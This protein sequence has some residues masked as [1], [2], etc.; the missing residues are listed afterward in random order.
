MD[1]IITTDTDMSICNDQSVIFQSVMLFIHIIRM[2]CRHDIFRVLCMQQQTAGKWALRSMAGEG[3]LTP[4]H[5]MLP[6]CLAANLGI[7]AS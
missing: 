6:V 1:L 2:V 7:T 4:V 3:A 5:K